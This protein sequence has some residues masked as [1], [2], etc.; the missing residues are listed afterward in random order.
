MVEA[1]CLFQR[2]SRQRRSFAA[3]SVGKYRD[4]S[5]IFLPFRVLSTKFSIQLFCSG[6]SGYQVCM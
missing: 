4:G 5:I 1:R 3:A 6:L 2:V